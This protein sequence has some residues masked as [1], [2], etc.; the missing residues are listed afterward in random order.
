MT[1]IL[2]AILRDKDADTENGHSLTWSTSVVYDGVV[3]SCSHVNDSSPSGSSLCSQD[4][5]AGVKAAP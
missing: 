4:H 5:H 2:T 3:V 1:D